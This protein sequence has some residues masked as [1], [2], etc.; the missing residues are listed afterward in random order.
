ML[1]AQLCG[2]ALLVCV[3]ASPG[4]KLSFGG[5]PASDAKP[6]LWL[7]P[8]SLAQNSLFG[9]P[10]DQETPKLSPCDYWS[11]IA[12]QY[13]MRT[14]NYINPDPQITPL[15]KN[16]GIVHVVSD[17]TYRT[18]GPPLIGRTRMV[19][20]E[21][22]RSHE[23]QKHI[24]MFVLDSQDM[25]VQNGKFAYE[26][27][28][29]GWSEFQ[30]R[31]RGEEVGGLMDWHSAGF[32]ATYCTEPKPKKSF[33]ALDRSLNLF[34]IIDRAHEGIKTTRDLEARDFVI[35]TTTQPNSPEMI[36]V[37]YKIAVTRF[38][39]DK[40]G[41]KKASRP[42][43]L[44]YDSYGQM[45]ETWEDERDRQL[46]DSTRILTNSPPSRNAQ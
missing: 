9:N 43:F 38:E 15:K 27:R 40:R 5:P 36:N 14:L 8:P 2:L 19:F 44:V 16:Q 18:T 3:S 20:G 22:V 1:W 39:L 28:L 45:T 4:R 23:N 33:L 37:V 30:K 35:V 41:S 6:D 17:Y 13:N 24:E 11:T 26:N 31:S 21:L 46:Q 7:N 12:T 29:S 34:E 10:Q 25:P 32:R 42:G